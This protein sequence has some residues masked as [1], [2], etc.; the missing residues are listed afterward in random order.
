[1]TVDVV[2]VDLRTEI[3]EAAR[4]CGWADLE[5]HGDRFLTVMADTDIA[6]LDRTKPGTAFVSP[7]N[8]FGEMSG[9]VDAV[10]AH[11]M[12]PG[13]EARVKR[14]FAAKG[15]VSVFGRAMLPVGEAVTVP[16][17]TPGVFLIA[18]PTMVRPGDVRGSE[19]AYQA[20]YAALDEAH[21][22]NRET[23][24]EKIRT[25]ITTAMCTGFGMMPPEEAVRQM[26]EAHADVLDR[27][28]GVRRRTVLQ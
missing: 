20:M 3:A 24:G 2:L 4:A 17:Q 18:A 9:G 21:R 19:N 27:W 28:R 25:L 11:R 12:F 6:A 1:M 15:A 16:T 23:S 5:R 10:L 22:H 26:M 7:A 13:V 8:S 14:A